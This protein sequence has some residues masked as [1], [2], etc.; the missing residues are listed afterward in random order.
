[1]IVHQQFEYHES[2]SPQTRMVHMI[3]HDLVHRTSQG[4]QY[5]VRNRNSCGLAPVIAVVIACMAY[6]DS[7]CTVELT[8]VN[9]FL[10]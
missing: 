3:N 7:F 2:S 9:L 5:E 1:M 8:M 4:D 6:R 10:I